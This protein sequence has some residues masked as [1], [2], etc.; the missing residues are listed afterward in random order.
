VR[1]TWPR[2]WCRTWRVADQRIADLHPA[3]F[4]MS[5]A[6]GVVS[7]GSL[8]L[9][10]GLIAKALLAV[11]LIAYPA[12]VVITALRIARHR[13]RFMADLNDHRRSVG[14]F[15]TVAATSVL[16]SQFAVVGQNLMV[17][18]W[19][20]GPA[21]GLWAAC[22]YTVFTLLTVREEKPT[23][24]EGINGG[25]LTAV[26]ATQS[27]CVLGCLVAPTFGAGKDLL[28]FVLL[29]FWLCGGMLYIWTI[30]LIFY[31]YMFFRFLP[32]DLMPPYWINMGA[33][34]ISALAGAMLIRNAPAS[35]LLRELLPFLKG[36]SLWYWATATWWI[37]MLVIL[38]IWRHGVKRFPLTYDPLY[39]GAVFPLGMYT[40]ATFRI[41]AVVGLPALGHIPRYFF[42]VA[43][44]AWAAAFLGLLRRLVGMARVPIEDT[45]G[46]PIR[47]TG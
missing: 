33:M 9:G 27:I 36:F 21:I 14:L 30:S 17:G 6:T 15:T 34:A 11:N 26:V 19:L 35:A 42:C 16:G 20:L 38:A 39:W 45:G 41:A 40:V 1:R 28:L 13:G 46:A 5:M 8:L 32:S 47:Q 12:L 43:A 44:V 37:P 3:Y 18:R 7:M 31:R 24:A 22:M 4:A 25:W 10:F 29:A 23:L 2:T